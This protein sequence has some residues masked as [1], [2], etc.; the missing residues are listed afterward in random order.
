MTTKTLMAMIEM[1][2]SGMPL[3]DIASSVGVGEATAWQ[4]IRRHR[5]MFPH[6]RNHIGWWRER[7]KDAEGLNGVQ[8][9]RK[10]G[11]SEKTVSYWRRKVAEHD[12]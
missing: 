10:L 4:Y 5:E 11:V 9:A 2:A 7:L 3:S 8:A 1:W 6:R 12:A